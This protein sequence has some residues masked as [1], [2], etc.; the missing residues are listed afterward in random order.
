MRTCSQMVEREQSRPKS[1][2][3]QQMQ[4][5]FLREKDWLYI[6]IIKKSIFG[7]IIYKKQ[8]SSLVF[9][10]CFCWLC[11]LVDFRRRF[12]QSMPYWRHIHS[13]ARGGSIFD[14]RFTPN[15]ANWQRFSFIHRQKVVRLTP[16]ASANSVLYALFMVLSFDYKGTK[17]TRDMQVKMLLF[18]YPS[19]IVARRS[20]GRKIID[21]CKGNHEKNTLYCYLLF[22]IVSACLNASFGC[23]NFVLDL[24]IHHESAHARENSNELD[25]PLA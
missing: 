5:Q 10:C 7:D 19:A 3:M 16:A 18:S 23:R 25:S 1:Q 9:A 12:Y 11:W 20:Q 24:E 22:Q 6:I 13:T 2:Q 21:I 17:K 4:H 14:L 15:R 8:T